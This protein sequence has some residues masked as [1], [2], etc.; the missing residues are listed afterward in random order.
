LENFVMRYVPSLPPIPSPVEGEE[1]GPV[2]AIRPVR[3]VAPRT[4]VPR[5]IQYFKRGTL[6]GKAVGG[7]V[8]SRQEKREVE[9]RRKWCR[10]LA[11]GQFLLDTRSSEDRRRNKRRVGDPSDEVDED[12]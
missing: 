3:P 2:L 9:T 1:H 10:R 11:H 7:A 8:S 12:I 6:F 5:V 4:R